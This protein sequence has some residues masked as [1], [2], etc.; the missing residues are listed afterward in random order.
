[1]RIGRHLACDHGLSFFRSAKASRVNAD[2]S[3]CWASG[4]PRA[5]SIP[6][7]SSMLAMNPLRNQL[8]R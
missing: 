5:L 6:I 2:L 8:F 3:F 7:A 4:N 1:M